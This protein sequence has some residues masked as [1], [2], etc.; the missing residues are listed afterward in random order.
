MDKQEAKIVIFT[1]ESLYS[2]LAMSIII[3]A[4]ADKICLICLSDPYG[5]KHGGL[6][7]QVV[8][9][10]KKSGWK[11]LNYLCVV[12]VYYLPLIYWKKLAAKITGRDFKIDTVENMAKRQG[13][14][15]ATTGNINSEEIEN[16]IRIKNPDLILSFYFDQIIKKNIFA[17]PRLGSVNV[18]PAILP[19]YRGPFPTFWS[20]EK[21]EK[22]FG[23]TMHFIDE[24]F[25]TGNI[26]AQ[27]K[28]SV[29]TNNLLILDREV[30]AKA[31]KAAPMIINGLLNGS[32][33]SAIKQDGGMYYT[34]PNKSEIISFIKKGNRLFNFSSFFKFLS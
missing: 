30:F 10:Y 11:F 17:I 28:F 25:D 32:A 33:G 20:L 23:Y 21:G 14:E 6:W 1:M 12:F 22:E 7:T 18:H 13:I 19:D 16:L 31:A 2:S 29:D 15:V 8:K 27:E 5:G 24:T 26:I 9:N 4:M 3:P 34:Y